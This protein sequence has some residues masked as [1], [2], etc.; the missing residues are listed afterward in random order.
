MPGRLNLYLNGRRLVIVDYAHNEAGLA[1]LL[2]T[3]EALLGPRGRRTGTLS[4]IIGTAGDRPDDGLREVGRIAAARADEVAIKESLT[5]L[6][7]RTRA[8]VVGEL[9]GGVRAAGVAVSHVPVYEDEP[10]AVRGELTAPGRLAARDD[11][12]PRTVLLMC[13]SQRDEVEAYLKA[14]GFIA[15]EEIGDLAEFRA[16]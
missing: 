6:R 7:G 10:A 3:A 12:T 2:D 14:T 15:V 8:G 4:A 1:A 11:G 5:L 9:K 13:H 16:R